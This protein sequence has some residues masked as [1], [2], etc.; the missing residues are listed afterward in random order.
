MEAGMNR[1]MRFL[2][3]GFALA[4]SPAPALQAQQNWDQVEV[5]VSPIRGGIHTITAAGGN[6]AVLPGPEGILAVDADYAEM[7]PRI[8][9]S[10]A[11][12]A[13]PGAAELQY[14]VNTHWHFDHTSGNEAFARAGATIIAHEGVARL[15]GEDQTMPA[16]GGREVPAAPEEA[17]PSITFNDRLN[18]TFNGELIH[19]VHMPAAHTDGDIIVHFRDAD[20]IHMGDIFFNGMYPFIDVD[21]GGNLVGM[22]RALEEVLSHSR[23]TTLFIPGHG[24][25]ADRAGLESYADAL[26]TVRD[27]VGALIDAGM[28]RDQVIAEKPTADLDADYGGQGSFT[29]PDIWVGLVYDGM[30]R[31]RDVPRSADVTGY[32]RQP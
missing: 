15:L 9:A 27:R 7:A 30:V 6:L 19:L 5:R 13:A 26:K 22:V 23:E 18:L 1:T 29:D 24:P 11:E 21:H 8:L 4:L 25:L 28:S 14:L 12:L 3:L 31:G 17:Q 32:R 20:V 2:I 10:I 16:L